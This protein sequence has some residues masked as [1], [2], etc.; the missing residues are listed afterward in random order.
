MLLQQLG[1][2]VWQEQDGTAK[3]GRD[4]VAMCEC[5]AIPFAQTWKAPS[6]VT[7][8]FDQG[9]TDFYGSRLGLQ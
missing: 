8:A 6:K 7:S 5:D 1:N 3:Y 2:D 4:I 9:K